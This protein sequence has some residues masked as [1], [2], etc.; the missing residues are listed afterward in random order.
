MR[1]NEMTAREIVE[2]REKCGGVCVVPMGCIERHGDHL[3]VGIDYMKAWHF[4]DR[5]AEME[6]F[7]V[8]PGWYL[9]SLSD[10]TFAPGTI[11]FPLEIC[12][13]ALEALCS[14]IARNGFKKILLINSHGGNDPMIQYFLQRFCEK[15]RDYMVYYPSHSFYISKGMIEA[16]KKLDAETNSTSGH[17]GGYE[18]AV[19]LFLFPQCVNMSMQLPREVG[20]SDKR[21]EYMLNAGL[22]VPAWWFAAHPHHCGGY[23][24][25]CT[26]EYGKEI[27]EA[28][29]RDI[30]EYVR[31]I[32]ADTTTME[33]YREFRERTRNPQL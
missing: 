18:T 23:G 8:F 10:C 28:A 25:N 31:V 4:V 27:V 13:N 9:G 26:A 14:E 11:A 12:V 7:M 16:R 24:N 20:I 17:A 19:S 30:A 21:S 5:A 6:P 22:K 29:A 15:D 32:K 3:P 2:A 1:W 33:I